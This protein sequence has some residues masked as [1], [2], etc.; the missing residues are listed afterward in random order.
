MTFVAVA[1]R[2]DSDQSA[3]IGPPDQDLYYLPLR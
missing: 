3:S 2:I 1:S